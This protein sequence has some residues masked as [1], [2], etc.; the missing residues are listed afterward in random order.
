MKRTL[1]TILLA[2]S[3]L[4]AMAVNPVETVE[5]VSKSRTCAAALDL[6]LTAA[7]SAI[8]T[9][10]TINLTS[11][12]AWLFFDNVRPNEVISTYAAQVLIDGKPMDV[13]S[14]C[15]VVIY[16][17]GAVVMPYPADIE[18]LTAYTGVNFTGTAASYTTDIYYCNQPDESAPLAMVK[19]MPQDN[20]IRS[21]RLKRGYMAAFACD[22]DGLGYNRIFIAD[23][24]DIE[25]TTLPQELDHKISFIRVSKWQYTS[26]KG[27]AGSYWKQAPEGL[28]YVGEQCD[29]TRSTWYY[30][31]GSSALSTTNPA[32]ADSSYNQEFVPEKW[33]AGGSWNGIFSVRNV[34]HLMGYNEPDHTEQSN[35]SVETAI[36]EW[37]RLMKT[38]LRLGSPATTN[39]SWI[40]SFMKEAKKRNYRVDYV[41]VHAYWGGLSGK[42][43]YDKL[44]TI[45]E[46]TGCP[47]WIKEWNNGA[48][49]T[50]EGWPSGTEAQQ[51]KQLSDLREI[52]TV[53]DTTSFIERY[54]IYNWV[55]DKR[56]VILDGQLTP[57]G[58]YYTANDSP[59]FLN[60]DKVVVP[61][62][63]VRE[64]PVLSY[65]G[66]TS[67]DGIALSWTD[68]NGEQIGS[69]AVE[70]SLGDDYETIDR[71]EMPCDSFI[72]LP[73]WG[74]VASYVSYRLVQQPLSGSGKTSN[75]VHAAVFPN[76][77]DQPAAAN[78]L[79]SE[80]WALAKLQKAS[81]GM[82]YLLGPAT[83]RNKMPFAPSLRHVLDD[84]VD[85]RLATYAYQASPTLS[86]PD[87]IALLA[88]PQAATFDGLTSERSIIDGVGSAWQT[89]NFTTAFT[90][91]P[92]VFATQISAN[93]DAASAVHIQNVTPAGFQVS[94]QHEEATGTDDVTE[95][96][97]WL[98]VSMGNGKLGDYDVSVGLT[99]E[100]AVGDNLS[101]GYTVATNGGEQMPLFFAQM[102]THSDCITSTL[103]IKS[104]SPES[105]TLIKDR[106]KSAS[107]GS[108]QPEQVGWMTLMTVSSV[109]AVSPPLAEAASRVAEV[110]DLSGRRLSA[111]RGLCI[112]NG[113]KVFFPQ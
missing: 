87:T 37:P 85:L 1:F 54:S 9:G 25:L 96:V 93:R 94:V 104:R 63:R 24:A 107:Y 86:S 90:S 105:V 35:V 112:V 13:K 49:W 47:L 92:A 32:R 69:Y 76:A 98:A 113:Q 16:K 10:A 2:I 41:V 57:A 43:W 26:K 64:A 48:N 89:V 102:Q 81:E 33:G 80:N 77:S 34:S 50:S 18:P 74:D 52:L 110:Y 108:T 30:N 91:T 15:R 19:A 56:A 71:M 67:E 21:F 12:K 42:E 103:R 51:Q 44:N 73:E 38:G 82:F 95:Q 5:R 40:F 61:T 27:W 109:S 14:N 29:L 31:W 68:Y 7:E 62:W 106:E 8:A 39:N 79:V 58:E 60:P 75:V 20:T 83:Y 59:Y 66:Y 99:S 88:L 101:G 6:H 45:H 4:M 11:E 36:E 23:T 55:E 100:A 3:G 78:L 53:M 72:D 22:A 111:P 46:T 70:R 65:S 84:A 28:K 97:A 17:Q